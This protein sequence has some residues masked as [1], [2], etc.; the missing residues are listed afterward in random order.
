MNM[1]K[2]ILIG[3]PTYICFITL[4]VQLGSQ[5]LCH[6]IS[7]LKAI[8]LI[9][10]DIILMWAT[11]QINKQYWFLVIL[12]QYMVFAPMWESAFVLQIF[13]LAG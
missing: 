8:T 2:L 12:D 3:L 5:R 7:T 4:T 13:D 10:S 9:S 1:G 6:I 11:L